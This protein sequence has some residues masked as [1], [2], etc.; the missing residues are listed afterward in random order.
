M[1]K[2]ENKKAV[3]SNKVVG[4]AIIIVAI[5]LAIIAVKLDLFNDKAGFDTEEKKPV[6]LDPTT[7]YDTGYIRVEDF[8]SG[9][10]SS[11]R[12]QRSGN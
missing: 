1:E 10:F 5:L 4:I 3:V 9:D 11:L 6:L 8:N 12:R 7:T 2:K